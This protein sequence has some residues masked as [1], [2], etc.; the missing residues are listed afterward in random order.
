VAKP[1]YIPFRI[2]IPCADEARELINQ[3]L[4]KSGYTTG[5]D[6]RLCVFAED[7][8]STL[9]PTLMILEE[10]GALLA[11]RGMQDEI[12]ERIRQRVKRDV[13]LIR[14]SRAENEA[15]G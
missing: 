9:A 1:Y 2:R 15:E 3:A 14:V 6:P 7:F 13:K 8:A 5:A 10:C 11:S 4:I 12:I